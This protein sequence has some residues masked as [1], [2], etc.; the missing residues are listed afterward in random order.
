MTEPPTFR[1]QLVRTLY[2]LDDATLSEA[3][4]LACARNLMDRLTRA[5][6]DLKQ[7]KAIADAVLDLYDHS[8][9]FDKPPEN[10]VE[11]R[12]RFRILKG[13]E[14]VEYLY[15]DEELKLEEV[16]DVRALA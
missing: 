2:G 4:I 15:P 16:A 10:E 14:E 13:L 8:T 9:A 3:Q 11:A 12:A 5:E 7:F 6:S 1:D